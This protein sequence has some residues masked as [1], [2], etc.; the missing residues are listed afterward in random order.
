MIS[1]DLG[2]LSHTDFENKLFSDVFLG[3]R[4]GPTYHQVTKFLLKESMSSY[5]ICHM[6]HM[7]SLKVICRMFSIVTTNLDKYIVNRGDFC[8]LKLEPGLLQIGAATANGDNYYKLVHNSLQYEPNK[9]LCN[10][11]INYI[12]KNTGTAVSFFILN[13]A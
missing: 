13:F 11:N 6:S 7:S 10:I 1:D 5:V 2:C 8:Y 3:K 12:R 4:R 9:N